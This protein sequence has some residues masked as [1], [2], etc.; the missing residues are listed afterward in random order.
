MPHS[1]VRAMAVCCLCTVKAAVKH[2]MYRDTATHGH[3]DRPGP[4]RCAVCVQAVMRCLL[5][6]GVDDAG[7]AHESLCAD[8]LVAGSLIH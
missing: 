6:W 2:L 4:R 5:Y 8:E 3:M 1:Q 7:Y